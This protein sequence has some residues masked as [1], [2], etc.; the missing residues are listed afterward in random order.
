MDEYAK[1]LNDGLIMKSAELTMQEVTEDDLKK[2]NKFTLSPLSAEQVFTFK[3]MV[4]DNE[5]DDRNCEPFNAAALKDLAKLYVGKTVIK[6]HKRSADNQVARIYDT[7]L[8]TDESKQT[9]AGEPHTELMVKCYMV[10]TASNA[11]LI[12]EI[13]AGIKRE[14]SSSCKP[15]HA[16]CSICGVDNTKTWCAHYPGGEYDAENGKQTC[17]FTLDGAKEAYELSLVAVPA[18]PRA[19]TCKNYG[20]T[21]PEKQ[22]AAE[23]KNTEKEVL[24]LKID[25][26]GA[27][28]FSK[29]QEN[30]G[31]NN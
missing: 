9:G 3:V 27:F 4:G 2:I 19:G 8:S 21:E 16:K 6:D 1:T 24:S 7:Q 28:I 30:Y 15:R 5:L 13:K 20:A 23:E 26:A 29:K 17:Y 31:G 25:S 11:D 10:K 22:V 12:T 18:Q 14:V